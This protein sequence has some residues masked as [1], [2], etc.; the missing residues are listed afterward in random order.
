MVDIWRWRA[1]LSDVL[2]VGICLGDLIIWYS[3]YTYFE[4]RIGNT[5]KNPVFKY[6]IIF[7]VA[8]TE[9]PV[10]GSIVVYIGWMEG[11]WWCAIRKIL[12]LYVR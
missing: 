3:A 10:P 6:P 2:L 12:K 9:A 1:L 8:A 4:A 7:I 5:P 11:D